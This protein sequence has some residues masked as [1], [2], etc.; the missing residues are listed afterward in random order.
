MPLGGFAIRL[1]GYRMISLKFMTGNG[2]FHYGGL[3]LEVPK[4]LNYAA[5]ITPNWK[6]RYILLAPFGRKYKICFNFDFSRISTYTG[7]SGWRLP[8]CKFYYRIADRNQIL[9]AIPRFSG[10]KFQRT[11]RR[12]W[13]TYPTAEFQGGGRE[14]GSSYISGLNRDRNEILTAIDMFPGLE[15]STDLTPT[16]EI[17]DADLRSRS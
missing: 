8:N 2:K 6:N 17:Q 7:I 11:Y 15:V 13:P 14:T 3:K 5:G 1:M 16:R 10:L 4:Y 12:Q 9:T